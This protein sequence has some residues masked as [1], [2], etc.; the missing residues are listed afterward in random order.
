MSKG[1]RCGKLTSNERGLS[2]EA[3][4]RTRAPRKAPFAKRPADATALR[5][6]LATI[7]GQGLRAARD[8]AVLA[9]GISAALRRSELVA[10][11]L[12]EVLL[13]PQGLQLTIAYS[14]TDQVR[15][16]VTVAIPEGQR[17]RPKALLLEWIDQVSA[18]EAHLERTPEELARVPLFRR[19]TRNDQLTGQPMSDRAVA[20]LVQRC[21]AAAGYDPGLFAG[22]SLR[23]VS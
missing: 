6:L 16:G 9:I 17:I 13:V 20:R 15:E 19:L 23:Q 4:A 21:A 12:A 22:H 10:F 5:A 7:D 1:E 18:F 14:K 11:K 8:R 2:E 3:I